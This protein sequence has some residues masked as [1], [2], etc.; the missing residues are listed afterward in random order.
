MKRIL[1]R[2]PNWIGDQVMAF[3]FYRVLRMCYP[4]AWIAVVCTEWV[5]DIQF[6]GLVDEVFVLPKKKGDSFFQAAIKLWKFSRMIKGRGSWDLGITLPNSFGTALLLFLAGAQVRRGYDADARGFLLTEKMRFDTDSGTHRAHAYLKLLEPE[7][8]PE[9]EGQEYWHR[10]GDFSFDPYQYWPDIEPIETP[11]EPFF[12]VAPG[13]T[14]DSRRWTTSQFASLIEQV[15]SRHQLKAVVVGGT[16]EKEI[17]AELFRRGIPI[18]DYTGRGWVAAHWKLFKETRFTVCNESGLAHVAALCGSRVQIVCG[19]ADP[20]R[21]KPIG[22]G[23]VQVKI[24][25]V[26]C[27]PC[28]KNLCQFQDLRKN[29]CLVGI[30]PNHILEEIEN[31]I[32]SP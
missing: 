1:V 18:E 9:F 22:P 3:P 29:Q 32:L 23:A 25:P 26:S 27:W 12:I 8:L 6:K 4:D 13:A 15:V 5:K 19:A 11:N 31:A 17:A 10:S 16:A 30:H 14:A 28:E 20:R 7:G 2:A 21:T 24:N